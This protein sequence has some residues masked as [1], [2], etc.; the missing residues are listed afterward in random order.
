M[1]PRRFAIK[2]PEHAVASGRD[3]IAN[4]LAF[5]QNRDEPNDE[6]AD[7]NISNTPNTPN[8]SRILGD[9]FLST[10]LDLHRH[11]RR[12]RR[13]PSAAWRRWRPP[14]P[15]APRTMRCSCRARL[16][17][18][19][20]F[21]Q[22]KS[23]KQNLYAARRRAGGRQA[24]I[25][26]TRRAATTTSRRKSRNQARDLRSQVPGGA[27]RPAKTTSIATTSSPSP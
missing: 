2:A 7:R 19:W 15:S 23:V 11:P 3:N 21:Y 14:R 1:P 26:P 22:A 24:R 25:S 27:G 8:M 5:A 18:S 17:D 6:F 20:A 13:R 4:T 16:R 10:R 9:D 12:A